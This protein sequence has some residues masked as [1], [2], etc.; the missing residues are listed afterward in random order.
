MGNLT[1]NI[2]SSSLVEL[3]SISVF[4]EVAEG[5]SLVSTEINKISAIN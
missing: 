1:A 2:I 4:T 3:R 5:S